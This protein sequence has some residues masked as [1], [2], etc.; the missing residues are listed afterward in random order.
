MGV[1]LYFLIGFVFFS[2][3]L[4]HQKL[5]KNSFAYCCTILDFLMI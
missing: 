4:L 1:I 2:G 3:G 5:G